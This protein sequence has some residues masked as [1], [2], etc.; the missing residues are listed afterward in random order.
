MTSPTAHRDPEIASLVAPGERVR[1]MEVCGGHT[2]TIY[3]HGIGDLGLA[4]GRRPLVR[5]RRRDWLRGVGE[6]AGLPLPAGS[7]GRAFGRRHL[8][9]WENAA[10]P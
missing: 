8:A 2:H 3:R 1:I 4:A 10:E 6:D 7:G 5:M 9:R